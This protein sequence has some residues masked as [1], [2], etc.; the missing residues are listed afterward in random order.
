MS[1]LLAWH[2]D[3]PALREQAEMLEGDTLLN[4]LWEELSAAE[5]ESLGQGPDDP[6]AVPTQG[7]AATYWL[8]RRRLAQVQRW[9]G[10]A[11]RLPSFWLRLLEAPSACI[12]SAQRALGVDMTAIA[13][14]RQPPAQIVKW[15]A[16]LGNDLACRVL[17]RIRNPALPKAPDAVVLR[18]REAYKRAAK[19]LTSE[20]LAST[21]GRGLM[22]VLFRQ[23]PE[24]ERRDAGQLSRTTLPALIEHDEFLE[25]VTPEELKVGA[26][27]LA[28]PGIIRRLTTVRVADDE[29]TVIR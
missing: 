13:V 29:E 12:R 27:L 2:P 9:R 24:A 7:T 17:E 18:W 14:S 22:A 26:K 25:P 11:K 16:P 5:R 21:M 4:L 23:L 19:V 8:R 15:L 10:V 3:G 28:D 1:D 20:K 6:D